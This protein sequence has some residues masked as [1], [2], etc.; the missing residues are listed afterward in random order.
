MSLTTTTDENNVVTSEYKNKQGE[1]VET[2]QGGLVTSYVYNETGSL[3]TVIPPKAQDLAVTLPGFKE[4]IFTYK[5]D[6]RKRIV[7]KKIPGAVVAEM[8]YDS[9][10]RLVMSRTGNQ[11]ANGQWKV[12]LYDKFDRPVAEY[13]IGK[14]D[15]RL[16]YESHWETRTVNY[17]RQGKTYLVESGSTDLVKVPAIS[18]SNALSYT[19]YDDYS[20]WDAAAFNAAAFP[21]AAPLY[22]NLPKAQ[23][24]GS[25]IKV[26]DG[27]KYTA[28]P[29]WLTTTSYYDH[30][31]RVVQ[32]HSH[33]Y[34]GT[35]TPGTV[36][37]STNYSF[38]GLPEKVKEIQRFNGTE[39][40]I[41]QRMEYDHARRLTREYHKINNTA[42]VLV[43]K[44]TYDELG[45]LKKT[46]QGNNETVTTDY[47]IRG[48]IDKSVAGKFAYKLNY[49]DNGNIKTQQWNRTGNAASFG[50]TYNYTYDANNRL[51]TGTTAGYG[52]SLTYDA[53]GNITKLVRTGGNEAGTYEYT[54]KQ[55]N[56]TNQLEYIKL[57]GVTKPA[58][59][60]DANGNITKDGLR[61][62][63]IEYNLLNLPK[64][65][66]NSTN[67]SL[68]YIYDAAG[69]KLAK[70][71]NGAFVN[72][73][74][75]SVVYTG[76]RVCDAFS[77]YG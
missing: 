69:N 59:T 17:K 51:L 63:T 72:F 24:T 6:S 31:Y 1:V 42:E 22:I 54:Y 16:T 74:C 64:N 39:I 18:E 19:Y 20:G 8:V 12:Y 36:W 71:L 60:Y 77:G 52:E 44:N 70:K 41:T 62:L 5:Y 21:T 48:W 11:N 32:S 50:S 10:N 38:D 30:M 61:N 66:K 26:L 28:T 14:T 53:N 7:E 13:I 40:S 57:N 25:R 15:S 4:L 73:Y 47:N 3:C 49:Y 45:R 43:V 34:N 55:D 33:L 23:I 29:K 75:G 37:I 46:R 35:T 65:V 2:R 56:K 67:G 68:E 27:T 58:Y 76:S 9:R